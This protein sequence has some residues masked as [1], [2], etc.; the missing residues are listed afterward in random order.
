MHCERRWP[1]TYIQRA[2]KHF[3]VTF[4]EPTVMDYGQSTELGMLYNFTFY[5]KHAVKAKCIH[6]SP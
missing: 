5:A 4:E 1:F 2:E 6:I 3:E